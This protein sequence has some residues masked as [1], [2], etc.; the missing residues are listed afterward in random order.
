MK[1]VSLIF[2]SFALT[3]CTLLE[4]S[5]PL[6]LYTL[7]NGSFEQSNLFTESIAIDMPLS[8]ASLNTNR[9]AL[10]PSPYQREY[11]ADASWPDRLPN[12]LQEA[13][14]EGLSQRWGGIYVN[15]LKTG[16]QARYVLHTEIQDFSVHNMGTTQAETIIKVRFKLVNLRERKVIAS[17]V[18]EEKVPLCAVTMEGIITAFN[19]GTHILIENA[20]SWVE[21]DVFKT[22]KVSKL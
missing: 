10:T 3:S 15:R 17:H 20:I 5:E 6:P 11:F 16:L 2:L 7:Q 4:T 22:I 19:E 1:Y 9:I 13:L 21:K 12:I 14:L 8:E 18:F